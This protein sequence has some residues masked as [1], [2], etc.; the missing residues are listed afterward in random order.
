MFEYQQGWLIWWGPNRRFSYVL[1]R[2]CSDMA[3]TR[4]KLLMS[5]TSS[6][7]KCIVVNF[8]YGAQCAARVSSSP[9]QSGVE[10]EREELNGK[11]R[12]VWARS[13]IFEGYKKL[14]FSQSNLSAHCDASIYWQILYQ[15]SCEL[16][17]G[18]TNYGLSIKILIITRVMFRFILRITRAI[19]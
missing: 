19:G 7:E 18:G 17:D 16:W 1:A 14:N 9:L 11:Q 6:R 4:W 10:I 12:W 3:T 2:L 5:I 13:W 8:S 15:L